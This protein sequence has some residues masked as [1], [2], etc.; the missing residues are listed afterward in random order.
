M[1]ITADLRPLQAVCPCD[2]NWPIDGLGRRIDRRQSDRHLTS[3]FYEQSTSHCCCT[4]NMDRSRLPSVEGKRSNT[5][6]VFL[7]LRRGRVREAEALAGTSSDAGWGLALDV[8]VALTL[9][10]SS[11]LALLAAGGV[12]SS[13]ED[14]PNMDA[15][16]MPSSS[17]SASQLLR[18][19]RM[20]LV[21]LL[22]SAIGFEGC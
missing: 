16:S 13:S 21:E 22:R 1:Q 9:N 20:T 5:Y 7:V 14:A 6:S 12:G 4:Y 8:I 17:V 11:F 10:E 18:L 3:T 15:G 19:S 2:W